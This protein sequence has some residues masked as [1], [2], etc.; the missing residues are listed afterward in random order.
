MTQIAYTLALPLVLLLSS[1]AGWALRQRLPEQHRDR[2]V[3]DAIRL[4]MSMMITFAAVVLGLLTSSAK[5]DF[6]ARVRSLQTYSVELIGL[7]QRLREFGSASDPVRKMIREYVAASIADSWPDEPLPTGIFPRVA[8]GHAQDRLESATLGEML[9][10]IDE[11]MHSLVATTP[12]QHQLVPVLNAQMSTVLQQRWRLVASGSLGVS[13]PFYG[14]LVLWLTIAFFTFGLSTP[15]SLLHLLVLA[16]AAVSVSAAVYLIVD[17]D[18]PLTGLLSLP[19]TPLRDVL[20]H[21]DGR[22]PAASFTQ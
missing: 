1:T 4:I 10:S 20:A 14:V 11:R 12:L 2:D 6:D 16:L 8:D 17:F 18:T 5:S 21:I 19:S 7:N 3:V 9:L 15:V 22:V 13:W